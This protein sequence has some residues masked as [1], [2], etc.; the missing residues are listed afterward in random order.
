M[1]VCASAREYTLTDEYAALQIMIAQP[2]TYWR[3]KTV[4]DSGATPEWERLDA[5]PASVAELHGELRIE[6]DDQIMLVFFADEAAQERVTRAARDAAS[7]A[8]EWQIPHKPASS[9][10]S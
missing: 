5:A 4:D 6:N 10:Q 3:V 2:I 9:S 8:Q 7:L 1:P